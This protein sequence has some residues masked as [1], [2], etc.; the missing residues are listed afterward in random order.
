VMAEAPTT[1]S[2][3]QM[4]KRMHGCIFH[5]WTDGTIPDLRETLKGEILEIGFDSDIVV[6]RLDVSGKSVLVVLNFH[7]RIRCCRH[8]VVVCKI[9]RR[10]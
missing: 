10:K 8:G 9:E 1:I 5:A 4:S 6:S 7:G 3:L 2:R